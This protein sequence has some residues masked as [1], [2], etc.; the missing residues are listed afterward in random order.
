MPSLVRGL[1]EIDIMFNT[2]LEGDA[3]EAEIDRRT[4]EAMAGDKYASPCRA[5]L[6]APLPAAW[7][8]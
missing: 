7:G 8:R 3:L 2:D 4:E 1:I 6:P 5:G